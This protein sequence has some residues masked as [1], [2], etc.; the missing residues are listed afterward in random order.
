MPSQTSLLRRGSVTYT[1]TTWIDHT[2]PRQQLHACNKYTGEPG[3]L[4]NRSTFRSTQQQAV[5]SPS[6]QWTRPRPRQHLQRSLSC[7]ASDIA[8]QIA[9]TSLPSNPPRKCI[10]TIVIESTSNLVNRH[11]IP[12]ACDISWST[13]HSP[14]L[15]RQALQIPQHFTVVLYSR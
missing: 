15:Q 7:F 9:N 8:G 10:Q 14:P 4:H 13:S 3:W 5:F 1:A 2:A 6:E 12:A 11:C